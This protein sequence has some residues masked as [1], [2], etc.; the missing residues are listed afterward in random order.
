MT[1]RAH[2]DFSGCCFSENIPYM[3]ILDWMKTGAE[4]GPRATGARS[5]EESVWY[6]FYGEGGVGGGR[7]ARDDP[8]VWS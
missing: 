8:K 5:L 6:K 1:V 7:G 3:G 2:F 4:V